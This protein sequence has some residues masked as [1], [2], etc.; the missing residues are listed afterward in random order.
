MRADDHP[1]TAIPLTASRARMARQTMVIRTPSDRRA[2][3]PSAFVRARLSPVS[4][5]RKD[6][7]PFPKCRV[8][9]PE[10]EATA[11]SHSAPLKPSKILNVL[12]DP[13]SKTD[14]I[15]SA[16]SRQIRYRRHSRNGLRPFRNGSPTFQERT[17]RHN[18]NEP[19]I[20]WE[21]AL[22]ADSCDSGDSDDCAGA[23]NSL[24]NLETL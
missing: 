22:P 6:G 17:V 10:D 5:P 24:T 3:L 12:P 9:F 14:S 11:P 15:R 20:L 23:G 2:G 16:I 18:G 1:I 4:M 13:I 19:S 7:W 21:R 8:R